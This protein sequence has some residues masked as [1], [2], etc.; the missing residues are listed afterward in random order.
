LEQLLIRRK[1]AF[2]FRWYARTLEYGSTSRS[3]YDSG[4]KHTNELFELGDFLGLCK[5]NGEIS[6]AVFT[7]T[8]HTIKRFGMKENDGK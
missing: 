8:L 1:F 5:G 3:G 4:E 7:A 6:T 2:F